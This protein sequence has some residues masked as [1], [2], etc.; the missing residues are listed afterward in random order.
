MVF[1]CS[2]TN[3][4]WEGQSAHIILLFVASPMSSKLETLPPIYVQRTGCAALSIHRMLSLP[5]PSLRGQTCKITNVY[6]VGLNKK[7]LLPNAIHTH[8][9]PQRCK[10]LSN[11]KIKFHN[12]EP[13]LFIGSKDENKICN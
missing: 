3:K 1:I 4:C 12:A 7:S 5:L 8:S 9:R 10:L 13:I 11:L 6:L 2:D